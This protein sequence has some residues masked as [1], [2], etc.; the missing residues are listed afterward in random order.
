MTFD[1]QTRRVADRYSRDADAFALHW[2]PYL[3]RRSLV[4][5]ER[6]P[7]AGARVVLDLG[8]GTGGL[9]A[10]LRAAAPAATV[11]GTDVSEGMLSAARQAGDAPLALMD[12]RRLALRD[13]CADVAIL[14]FVLH[15]LAEPANAL[16]ESARVLRRGGALGTVTW[17][18]GQRSAAAAIWSDVLAA[19][20]AWS[21]D[22]AINNQDLVDEPAK[23]RALL[24]RA[25]MGWAECWRERF[26]ERRDLDGWIDFAIG[27]RMGGGLGALSP[28]ARAACL[29]EARR[30]IAVLPAE[31][32]VIRSEVVYGL[33][34]RPSV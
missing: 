29:T 33:A 27:A 21:D 34:V 18:H 32:L 16:A 30:R 24:L 20:G 15:R 11:V 8:T 12:A 25:G 2:A 17:G 22:V 6:M 9:L 3:R 1:E 4:L 7:L 28:E 19:H 10:A 14:A 26:D 31:A 23:V 5:L 13:E